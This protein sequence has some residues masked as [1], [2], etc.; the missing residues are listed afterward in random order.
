MIKLS[1]DK[2]N[3]LYIMYS[4]PAF[5]PPMLNGSQILAENGCAVKLIGAG[6]FGAPNLSVEEIDG[7]VVKKISGVPSPGIAQKIHYFY[8][9]IV[10]LFNV[11]WFRPHWIYAS[12]MLAAPIALILSYLPG[13]KI[14]YH[15][16]DSQMVTQKSPF[17]RLCRK[18]LDKLA[19][20]S[21]I[22]VLPNERRLE[23]FVTNTERNK[24][25]VCVW[26]CPLKAQAIFKKE[27]GF[28]GNRTLYYHGSVAPERLPESIVDILARIRTG[29][30]LKVVGYETAGSQGYINH[31]ENKAKEL[32]ISEQV[33]FLGPKSY[34]SGL[35]DICR[36]CDVG[37][38]LLSKESQDE[39]MINMLGA[40]NKIFEYMACSLPVILPDI[41]EW[42]ETFVK[43]GYAL[44]CDPNDPGSI[45]KAIKWFAENP[46]EAKEMG[47][48]GRQKILSEWNY[49]N[50]FEPV[51]RA[52][53]PN[54]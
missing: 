52:I 38:A 28:Q 47:E 19:K 35:M 15:E 2:K 32:G 20:R 3:I 4:D 26:N 6:V 10:I 21:D 18:T 34:H 8:Y 44:A 51:S 23:R 30:R 45:E 50:Q 14:L 46:E 31:L 36:S 12:D 54:E 48:K 24:P 33:N 5:Y 49:E 11:L 40:S 29:L 22:C 53:A 25:T 17:M 1:K 37:L 39:N 9:F 42:V 27:K 41:P 7:R 16:H 43:P 13:L